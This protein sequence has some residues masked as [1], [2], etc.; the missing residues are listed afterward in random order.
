MN[1]RLQKRQPISFAYRMHINDHGGRQG[2]L[3]F[4]HRH[5]ISD[6]IRHGRQRLLVQGVVLGF[7]GNREPHFREDIPGGHLNQE[8]H[9]CSRSSYASTFALP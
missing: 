3:R 1:A 2:F 6:I 5:R 4:C 7:V 9:A 8:M